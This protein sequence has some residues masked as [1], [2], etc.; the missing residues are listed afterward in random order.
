MA[1]A[2][3]AASSPFVGEPPIDASAGDSATSTREPSLDSG[4][5]LSGEAGQPVANATA[6]VAAPQAQAGSSVEMGPL[7]PSNRILT[8]Y[9]HPHDP[10]MGILGEYSKEELLPLLLAE[11][12]NYEAADPTRPVIPGFEVIATVAQGSPGSDG[13]FVLATD[14]E[15]LVEYADFAEA[16]DLLLFLD[17]QFGR[18]SIAAELA[19]VRPLLSR[20]HVHLAL[21]PEFAIQ[22][23]ETPGIHIG[24]LT[25]EEIAVAQE[26]LA[27]LVREESL[28][29]K[30]LI[31]HQFREDMIIGKERLREMPGVQ[32]V[33]D[34]DGHGSP[35]LK[36][37]S[38]IYLIQ[39]Q[40]V[41]FSGFKL[42]YRQDEPL[43]TPR[44]VL[45]LSPSP[46]L[47]IYQ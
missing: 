39:E 46:D 27:Q 42:F 16:N 23:G 47:I 25:A 18:E 3:P 9:G 35:K 10:N 6:V 11:A 43:M 2:V 40:P 45:A 41:G 7:L 1:P 33:I 24:E 28:P 19:K 31:V 34:A 15:T 38:Y 37:D 30:I 14:T 22:E 5:L 36:I 26:L 21:D 4:L 8:Y 12:A 29:P 44:D 20:P 13:S 17:L 32:L